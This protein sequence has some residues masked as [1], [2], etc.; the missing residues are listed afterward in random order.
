MFH[1]RKSNNKINWLHERALRMTYNDQISSF[2]ELLDKDN[3][4]TIHHF[5]IQS[6][7]TELFKVINNVAATI[8]GDLFTT[9]HSYILQ[10]KPPKFVV[11]TV[12]TA[13]NG[14]NSIQYYGP[15]IWNM[16]PSYIKDSE[17]LDIFKGKIQ[18]WKPIN[19][20]CRLCKK[21]IPN[22]GFINQI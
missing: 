7:A 4:F 19:C 18:K 1:S 3:S 8:I 17:T 9:Y 20:P 16:I 2:Q 13:H 12:R 15:L 22:L 10:S 14:Q 21:Y 5:N 6:L 11:P